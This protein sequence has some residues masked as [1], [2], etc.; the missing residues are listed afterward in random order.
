MNASIGVRPGP[1]G[2]YRDHTSF[3]I[4]HGSYSFPNNMKLVAGHVKGLGF[5]SQSGFIRHLLINLTL[6]E[7]FRLFDSEDE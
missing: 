2:H 6:C 1:A 4:M 3:K 5:V 7:D